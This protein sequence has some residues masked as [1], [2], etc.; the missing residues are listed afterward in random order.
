MR[1]LRGG[2]GTEVTLVIIRG[3]AAEPHDVALTREVLPALPLSGTLVGGNVG[4]VRIGEFTSDTP[5]DVR[6]TVAQ[7]QT[8]GATALVLDLRG[9]ARGPLETGIETAR[10][11]VASG[12]LA[13]QETRGASRQTVGAAAGDGAITIPLAVLT[14]FGTAGAAE[15]L[16]AA[17]AGTK[18]AETLGERTNGRAARQ[19]LFALPDGGS[20][21][22]SYTWYLT[23][24]G[25]PIHERGLQPDMAVVQPDVDF[26]APASV[27]DP[28]IDR[29]VERL[30]TR[31]PS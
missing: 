4:Y 2:P 30:K 15:L 10:A 18:R 19:R 24:A 13:L 31:G 25:T 8:R 3:R 29:A 9:T 11:F 22:M 16:A 7:V 26:G 21:W 17:L 14:D 6:K 23:P 28:T 20:M 27:G 5:A 1:M 12:T